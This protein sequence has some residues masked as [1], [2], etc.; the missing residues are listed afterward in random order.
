VEL[1]RKAG[2]ATPIIDVVYVL[3]TER[4]KHLG[5]YAAAARLGA[6][7]SYVKMTRPYSEKRVP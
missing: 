1:A 5:R 7:T 6:P 2:I 4:A 3:T